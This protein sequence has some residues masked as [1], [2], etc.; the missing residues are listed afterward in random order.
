MPPSSGGKSFNLG[1]PSFIAEHGLGV[2]HV[3]AG[4]EGELGDGRGV[5]VD[6]VPFRVLRE[7]VAATDPAPLPVT[8]PTFS[9]PLVTFTA[10]DFERVKALTGAGRSASAGRTVAV[11]SSH[12]V[13]VDHD[14]DGTAEALPL[15]DAHADLPC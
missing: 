6:Q 15:V 11:A 9:S 3:D 4:L 10:S 14:L 2:V 1:R 13:A 8:A 5:D 7:E 12:G